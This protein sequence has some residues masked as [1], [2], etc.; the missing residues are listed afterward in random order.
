MDFPQTPAARAAAV[1]GIGAATLGV[2]SSVAARNPTMLIPAAVFGGTAAGGAALA[3]TLMSERNWNGIETPIALGIGGVIG[4]PVIGAALSGGN[5][6]A[7]TFGL[8]FGM[9]FAAGSIAGSITTA[10]AGD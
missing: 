3:A 4:G 5:E 7:A 1:T 8:I 10:V 2:G 6:A 9:A